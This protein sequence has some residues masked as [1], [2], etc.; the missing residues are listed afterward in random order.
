M[1]KLRNYQ[2]EAVNK[3]VQ[4]FRHRRDPAVVILPTGVNLHR[5]W[6]IPPSVP[7]AKPWSVPKCRC[8]SWRPKP[9]ARP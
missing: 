6:A 2:Q 5:V 3:T 1:Y 4:F 9:M 7:S 8:A